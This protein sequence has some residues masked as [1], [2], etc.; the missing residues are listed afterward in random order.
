VKVD[1][2]WSIKQACR[3]SGLPPEII[4]IHARRIASAAAKPAGSFSLIDA[5]RKEN[6]GILSC[7]NTPLPVE[8]C[9]QKY[10]AFVPAAGAASRFLEPFARLREALVA[11]DRDTILQASLQLHGQAKMWPLPGA[12]RVFLDRVAEFGE[13]GSEAD[14]GEVAL[15]L[16]R[17]KALFPFSCEFDGDFTFLSA[18]NREHEAFLR[19]GEPIVGEVYVSAH[20]RAKEFEQVLS[21]SGL[22]REIFEQGVSLSTLRFFSDGRVFR[23]KSGNPSLVPAGH[24]ALYALFGEIK[25]RMPDCDYLLIRNV[26]NVSG[27]STEVIAGV[28]SFTRTVSAL[29]WAVKE[30][31]VWLFSQDAL[32]NPDVVRLPDN[33]RAALGL[34]TGLVPKHFFSGLEHDPLLVLLELQHSLF[35]SPLG[36]LVHPSGDR[37]ALLAELRRLYKRP[38]SVLGQVPNSGKDVGGT[39]AFVTRPDGVREKLCIEVG[40]VSQAEVD[41]V[42]KNPARATHFNPV[43]AGVELTDAAL[44]DHPYWSVVRKR[45]AGHDVVYHES[46]LYEILGSSSLANVVFVEIPRLLFNPHKTLADKAGYP[47]QF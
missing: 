17:P 6:F 27:I 38:V 8:S 28:R 15:L 25:A 46:F 42:L 35:H 41:T 16:D 39:P 26:D 22:P 47:V 9:P 43:F 14:W 13:S 33:F 18:K 7:L 31:R 30:V 34:L 10:A 11:G 19:F 44:P 32:S 23:D 3:E 37:H 4:E 40:H 1:E 24:G 36:G 12:L 5:C 29:L 45:F 21:R 2:L 20:G